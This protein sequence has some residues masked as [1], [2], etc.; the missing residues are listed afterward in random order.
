MPSQTTSQPSARERLLAAA[1]E[2]FYEEGVHTVGI[3]R[4]IERAGVAKATLY[5][6]YGSKDELVRSYLTRRH[7]ARVARLT[8]AVG[9]YTDPRDRLLA[10]FE[11]LE[12]TVARHGFRG[13]AFVN[14]S[15]EASAGG[16]VAEVS[17]RSRSWTRDLFTT[18]AAAAGVAAPAALAE[19]LVMLY[20]G[21]MVA[22]QMDQNP[23]AAGAARVMAALLIDT[24]PRA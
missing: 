11:S 18:E 6:T 7:E 19:Q 10:I 8:G 13:C 1:D 16:A 24:A 12:K 22:A 4:I 9:Q 5:S 23:K 2:L 20:D 15:A 21:A 14:A 3:D 17:A